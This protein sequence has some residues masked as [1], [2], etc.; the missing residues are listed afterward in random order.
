LATLCAKCGIKKLISIPESFG[1]SIFGT[2]FIIS[3][4]A[5][6]YGV[7]QCNRLKTFSTSDGVLRQNGSLWN[8]SF[9]DLRN[10]DDDDTIGFLVQIDLNKYGS[11]DGTTNRQIFHQTKT[12][13]FCRTGTTLSSS[14]VIINTIHNSNTTTNNGHEY[15]YDRFI[16]LCRRR[17]SGA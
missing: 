14:V 13:E 2:E 8:E 6:Y 9:G 4:E 17:R 16:C 10:D 7:F 5:N 1:A 15:E 3:M 12:T 11:K